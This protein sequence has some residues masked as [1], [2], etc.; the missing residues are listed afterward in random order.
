MQTI[1]LWPNIDAGSDDISKGL[2]MY[3][4]KHNPNFIHFY[5]NFEVQDYAKVINNCECI[6]GNS[7]SAIREGSF[8]GVPAVNIGTRQNGRETED[9]IIHAKYNSKEIEN[10]IRKQLSHGK[11]TSSNLYG[12]GTAGEKIARILENTEI[13]IQKTLTY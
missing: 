7:S 8:L 11:Y 13:K 6:V 5:K 10:A 9:N 3:R 1:W 2:R 4:E 12:D